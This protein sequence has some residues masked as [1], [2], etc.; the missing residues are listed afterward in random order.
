MNP[1]SFIFYLAIVAVLGYENKRCFL[2]CCRMSDSSSEV[3]RRRCYVSVA[4]AVASRLSFHT[5]STSVPAL[6]S[7]QECYSA[8]DWWCRHRDYY[9]LVFRHLSLII[10]GNMHWLPTYGQSVRPS[11]VP[12][13]YLKNCFKRTPLRP[14]DPCCRLIQWG[15]WVGAVV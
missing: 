1:L 13:S 10:D 15:G 8:V 9:W 12:W 5:S 2:T 3:S 6:C 4:V 7:V 11:S 14:G